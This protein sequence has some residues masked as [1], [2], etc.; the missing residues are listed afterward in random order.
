VVSEPLILAKAAIV[1]GAC[2]LAVGSTGP[3]A[4]AQAVVVCGV[5]CYGP[6]QIQ[7]AYGLP[8]L[9][10]RGIT[11]Q[12]TTIAILELYGSPSIAN[13][14]AVFDAEFG[15]P[16]PPSLKVIQPAG[17][18]PV[19]STANSGMVSW[20]MET[21]LDVE[22]AHAVA[23]GAS[24]VLAQTPPSTDAGTLGMPRF[25]AAEEYI[26]THYHADVIS[27]SFTTTEQ[28]LPSQAAVEALSGVYAEAAAKNVTVVTS[29]G[30]SG[31]A[32]TGLDGSAYYLHPVISYPAGD[33][34]VTTVG[35]TELHLD[36]SGNRTAADSVWNDGGSQPLASGGGK[37]VLFARPAYQD[38]VR[39]VVGSARGVPD[40][41]M[42]AACSAPVAIYLSDT[43]RSSGWYP[44]SGTSEAAPLFAGIVALADQLAG[45]PLGLVNPALYEL[46]AE[47]AGG[48]VDV[49]SGSN[50]VSFYQ[51]GGTRTV[52]G[53]GARSGYSLAAGVGTVDAA[54]F[55]PE[56]AALAGRAASQGA[57]A[58]LGTMT[59][60]AGPG[61]SSAQKPATQRV[62]AWLRTA[63]LLK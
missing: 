45:H 8:S 10:S 55:V 38:A 14:L 3:A 28:A 19:Y 21:T 6:T 5:S 40:V 4:R 59:R 58:R 30:D 52:T 37:S 51:G 62:F 56:L 22:Y 49:T 42:S 27:Q 61:T 60:T 16:A 43:S 44:A 47:H 41:S 12:G 54:R 33:P 31:A 63:G 11:G 7:Q 2:A 48:I 23:P 57:P 13:D 9:F 35:G 20:A 46:S 32:G 53:Y 17:Q 15:L 36:A 24:I 39:N 18:V 29:S 1:L 25:V 50:T 26:L 34:L